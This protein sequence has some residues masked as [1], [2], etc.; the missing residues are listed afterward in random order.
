MLA[1]TAAIEQVARGLDIMMPEATNLKFIAAPLNE[2]RL[3]LE[4]FAVLK[5]IVSPN[6]TG[7]R[8][9]RLSS[10]GCTLRVPILAS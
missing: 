9:D 8:C 3:K 7:A 1:D 6:L 10:C 4:A 5:L 2:G